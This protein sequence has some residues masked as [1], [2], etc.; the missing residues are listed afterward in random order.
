MKSMLNKIQNSLPI[1]WIFLCVLLYILVNG[2]S[3][4]VKSFFIAG[5]L[6]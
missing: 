4:Y 3:P 2:A 6:K 5:Y 1:V